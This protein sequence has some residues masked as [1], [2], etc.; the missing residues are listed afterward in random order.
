MNQE[1]LEQ[2]QAFADK[3][4]ASVDNVFLLVLG[5]F[6]GYIG[7]ILGCKSQ[8]HL[9]TN[10]YLKHLVLIFI[11]YFGTNSVATTPLNP[12]EALLQSFTIWL[13]FIGFSRMRVFSTGLVVTMFIILYLVKTYR[14]YTADQSKNIMGASN[15]NLSTDELI[16]KTTAVSLDATLQKAERGLV[17]GIIIN[18]IVGCGLYYGDKRKE[19]SGQFEISKFLL[20][21]QNCKSFDNP[22]PLE[23]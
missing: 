19:Y 8:Y 3:A 1:K 21:V 13:L 22:E 5:M 17:L 11:I 4:V 7:N 18:I 23:S 9:T 15:D 12:A 10:M 2:I 14:E 6:A 20:G 16:E